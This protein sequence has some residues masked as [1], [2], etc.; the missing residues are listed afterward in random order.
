MSVRKYFLMENTHEGMIT[1]WISPC[2]PELSGVKV[3][4]PVGLVGTAIVDDG[5]DVGHNLLQ[6]LQMELV[7]KLASE[8]L[9]HIVAY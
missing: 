3:D 6:R 2:A 9:K 4:R 5:L 8:L 7:S 1:P